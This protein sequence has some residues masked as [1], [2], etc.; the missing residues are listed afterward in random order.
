MLPPKIA[1]SMVNL[2]PGDPSGKL[3]I[4]PFC[5]SGRILVEA[6]QLGYKV[7]G[8]D[9]ILSQVEA[10]QA[11]LKF[12]DLP[13]E[14]FVHDATH[15][16]EKFTNIDCIVTEPFMGKPNLRPDQV[17]Y[18][19]RGLG[20]LYLGCL[21]D[22]YKALKPGGFIVMVFPIL[23]GLKR[24]YS[25]SSVIDAVKNIGYNQLTRVTYARPEARVRREIIVLQKNNKNL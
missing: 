15:L 5:G 8:T 20:K 4:D 9:L 7:V 23:T 24:E 1:R 21:K 16:S 18:A 6:A 12:L 19:V 2:V 11:N 13:G 3:L 17:D 22:W 10:A 14:I 25:T